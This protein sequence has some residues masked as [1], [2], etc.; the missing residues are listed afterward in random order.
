VQ[1]VKPAGYVGVGWGCGMG[2]VVAS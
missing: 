2:W 1:C